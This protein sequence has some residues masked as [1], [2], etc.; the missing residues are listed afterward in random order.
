MYINIL[1]SWIV[2]M[3]EINGQIFKTKKEAYAFVKAK[4]YKLGEC[5]I[6]IEDAEEFQFFTSL[7]TFKLNEKVST[8]TTFNLFKTPQTKDTIHLKV[9][10]NNGESKIVS[11]CDCSRQSHS[12]D[13]YLNEAMRCAITEHM[14]DYKKKSPTLKCA[15]CKSTSNP[16]VD[17]IIPFFKIKTD[18]LMGFKDVPDSFDKNEFAARIFKVDDLEFEL[19]WVK[20]HNS[21]ATY[22]ILCR[23][24]NI[25]KGKKEDHNKAAL[26]Y[27]SKEDIKK[28]RK[29]KSLLAN[30][31]KY[32][33]KI[34][35][36]RYEYDSII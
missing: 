26:K 28:T 1:E 10:Y 21:K 23:T 5:V 25:K 15:F 7:V 32:E 2:T 6:T 9:I 34:K 30:I 27:A 29:K 18:F 8:I 36:L 24:C 13:N 20:Y 12:K 17:H 35:A 14:H 22:Q 33:D 4:I 16:Q 31:A 19:E 11:W 3:P